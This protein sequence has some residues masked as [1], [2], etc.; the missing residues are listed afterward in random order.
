MPSRGTLVLGVIG[1]DI[2]NIGITILA[3]AL[4]AGGFKVVSLGILV[5]QEEFVSA[6]LETAADAILVSSLYGH[7]ELDCPG[8]RDKCTEAGLEGILLYVGGNLV[9][10]KQDWEPVARKFEAMGYDRAYPPGSTP[11]RFI[12][13]LTADLARKAQ[14]RP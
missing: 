11:H 6:A 10:G 14:A 2:H 7:G 12:E 1:A 8:L 9:I 5:P 4:R 13:D 3:S